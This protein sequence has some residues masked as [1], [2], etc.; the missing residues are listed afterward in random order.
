MFWYSGKQMTNSVCIL[1]TYICFFFL[2]FSALLD[3][4]IVKRWQEMVERE[5]GPWHTAKVTG[6]NRNS[7]VAL[8]QHEQCAVT[9]QLPRRLQILFLF[10]CVLFGLESVHD[11]IYDT[12]PERCHGINTMWTAFC[13]SNCIVLVG[14]KCTPFPS[15]LSGVLV[16][17]D[18]KCVVGH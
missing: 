1:Y 17:A 10:V 13:C 15:G 16:V 8:M 6:W 11:K 2:A 4:V 18:R 7:E 9:S 12:Y 14:T 5:K 3:R